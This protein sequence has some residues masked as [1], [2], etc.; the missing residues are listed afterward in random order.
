MGKYKIPVAMFLTAMTFFAGMLI[1]KTNQNKKNTIL[2]QKTQAKT[3]TK[4]QKKLE[5]QGVNQ[6]LWAKYLPTI[7]HKEYKKIIKKVNQGTSVSQESFSN[8]SYPLH[9]NIST[10]Y[11]W[12]GE[13]AGK[14]NGGIDNH[15]SCWDEKWD[16]HC[17]NENPYY[18]ALPYN[19]FDDSG[20]RKTDASKIIPWAN[21]KKWGSQESM[22]KNHWIKIIHGN[23]V[24]YAQ[25]EDAGPFGE[26]DKSYVFG[27]SKPNCKKNENVGLDVS[28][29]VKDYLG[30]D[31]IDKTDWQFIDENNVPSGPWKQTITISQ[32]FWQ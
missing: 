15:S 30:L 11:F 23:K 9:T 28:P 26:D 29:A 25:W 31:D 1:I 17:K 3:K 10:T 14:D 19:D 24:A 27:S 20:N 4:W 8:G 22:C 32:I 12:V 21:E 6:T 2:I 5:S 16:Q 7:T 18:F 13:D